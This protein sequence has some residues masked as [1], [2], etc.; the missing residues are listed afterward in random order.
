MSADLDESKACFD[1]GVGDLAVLVAVFDD[2]AV[3]CAGSGFAAEEGE[4]VASC[5]Y[6]VD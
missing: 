1:K 2:H 5:S 3:D 4:H 6:V